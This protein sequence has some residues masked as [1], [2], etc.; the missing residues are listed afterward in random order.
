MSL[1][2][3]T[4]SAPSKMVPSDSSHP[5]LSALDKTQPLAG[6]V[7]EGWQAQIAAAL[8]SSTAEGHERFK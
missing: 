1:N 7:L 4:S 3:K 8:S 5:A 6:P 2:K